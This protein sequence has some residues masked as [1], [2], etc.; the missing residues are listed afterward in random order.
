MKVLELF[1]GTRSISK[2]FEARGHETFSIEWDKQHQ[3]IDWYA[4]IGAITTQDILDKFGVPDVIWASPDCFTKG[5]LVNVKDGYKPI[6]EIKIGDEVLTH[7]G[8]LKKV[9]NCITKYTNEIYKLKISGCEEFEVTGNHPFYARKKKR[10]NTHK[11]GEPLV[12]TEMEEPEWIEAKDLTN[13]YRVGIVINNES[14]LPQWNGVKKIY[15]NQNGYYKEYY[16][17][18]LEVLFDDVNFWWMMGRYLGDGCNSYRDDKNKYQFEICCNKNN[19]ETDE[20]KQVLDKL[21]FNYALSEKRTTNV[22]SINKKELCYFATKFGKGAE[23]KYIPQFVLDLPKDLLKSFIDGYLSADGHLDKNYNCWTITT[24]SEKLAYSLQMAILKAYNRYCSLAIKDAYIGEIE[25]RTVNCRKSYR[26][27]FYLE[28]TNRLQYVIENGYA[29]VNI[30]INEKE[31]KDT[32]VFT[33]SVEDNESY[34]VRNIIV[35]NCTSYSIAAISK[36]RTKEADGNLAPKSDY[37]KFCDKVNKHVIEMINEFLKIN[38]NMIYFIENPRGGMRKMNF[39]K[40]LP[41]YTVTYCQ[42]GDNRMK[43]TD[44]WTNHPNPR[45]KPMCKNGDPCHEPAPRGSKTGTQGLKSAKER[46]RIPKLLCE[47]IVDICEENTYKIKKC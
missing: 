25:G 19:N 43:P 10:I 31:N 26:L 38:P 42:Y 28:K 46:S 15:K 45:F 1:A 16:T 21:P 36:H 6:E 30:R 34:C 8:E 35:H 13:E 37:A 33:L 17:N 23:G 20:I 32:E 9:Y 5:T 44:L 2:A 29:W 22:F 27:G 47:H 18:E 24:V 39:M 11:N 40:N 3:N 12:Y 7:T 14:K 41:R 4:D